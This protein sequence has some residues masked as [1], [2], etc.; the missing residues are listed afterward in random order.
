[1]WYWTKNLHSPPCRLEKAAVKSLYSATK[2]SSCGQTEFMSVTKDSN[3]RKVLQQTIVYE[4][5]FSD[6]SCKIIHFISVLSYIQ[7]V[8]VIHC[9]IKIWL[10]TLNKDCVF[11]LIWSKIWL[12]GTCWRGYVSVDVLTFQ[13]WKLIIKSFDQSCSSKAEKNQQTLLQP[14]LKPTRGGQRL[15]S[16]LKRWI[17]HVVSL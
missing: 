5:N 6:F 14:P 10:N 9:F 1:M 2:N 13:L 3:G 16:I 17:L 4:R 15:I 11:T 7:H 8:P 12:F